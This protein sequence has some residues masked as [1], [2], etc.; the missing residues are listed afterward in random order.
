MSLVKFNFYE[1]SCQIS[2]NFMKFH[3]TEFP[4]HLELVVMYEKN[5]HAQT[6]KK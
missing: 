5:I 3:K 4:M 6:A 1:P 2:F